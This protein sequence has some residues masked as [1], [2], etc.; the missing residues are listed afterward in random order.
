MIGSDIKGCLI[1]PIQLHLLNFIKISTLES[2]LINTSSQVAKTTDLYS[3]F[4]QDRT[5]F[6]FLTFKE[7]IFP[8]MNT[9]YLVEDLQA[10]G[11]PTQFASYT[12]WFKHFLCHH[13]TIL[14]LEQPAKFSHL[15]ALSHPFTASR[16]L[17]SFLKEIV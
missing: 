3:A 17:A 8:Q 5:T 15:L 1:I 6:C 16:W 7:T 2:C 4:A 10:M 13:T 11:Q 9:Q 12:I 14:V